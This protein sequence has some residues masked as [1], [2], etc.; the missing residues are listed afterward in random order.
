MFTRWNPKS[1]LPLTLEKLADRLPEVLR[2]VIRS[3]LSR[4]GQNAWLPFTDEI[5]GKA[6]VAMSEHRAPTPPVAT[7]RDAGTPSLF[8]VDTFV[9]AHRPLLEEVLEAFITD[10]GRK[11]AT[12]EAPLS[13]LLQRALVDLEFIR[14]RVAKVEAV[15]VEAMTITAKPSALTDKTRPLAGRLR[16][17]SMNLLRKVPRGLSRDA[18]SVS[19]LSSKFIT[20]EVRY[21]N[22]D[23]RP[24]AAATVPS[25]RAA[26][27]GGGSL[28]A[29]RPGAAP[30]RPT[31]APPGRASAPAE[32]PGAA[33]DRPASGAAA[34]APSPA[35][36]QASA[37]L[38]AN[39]RPD[40]EFVSGC[41]SRPSW[42]PALA[43]D[44]LSGMEQESRAKD[45]VWLADFKRV[46]LET[47]APISIPRG[48]PGFGVAEATALLAL[49]PRA[50][51]ERARKLRGQQLV[52]ETYRLLCISAR[53][54]KPHK[55]QPSGERRPSP[56]AIAAREE[57][58]AGELAF[59]SKFLGH[60]L[61]W[62]TL[63]ADGAPQAA[64][65]GGMPPR[66]PDAVPGPDGVPLDLAGCEQRV[67][68]CLAKA[69]ALQ[70]RF[71]EGSAR[72]T[73]VTLPNGAEL[74]PR[75]LG[76]HLHGFSGAHELRPDAALPWVKHCQCHAVAQA[77]LF[78]TGAISAGVEVRVASAVA[79]APAPPPSLVVGE[80]RARWRLDDA[81]CGA[82]APPSSGSAPPAYDRGEFELV[83]LL[84]TADPQQ[85]DVYQGVCTKCREGGGQWGRAVYGPEGSTPVSCKDHASCSDR[86]AAMSAKGKWLIFASILRDQ[87]FLVNLTFD[88]ARRDLATPAHARLSTLPTP[89]LAAFPMMDGAVIDPLCPSVPLAAC[90]IFLPWSKVANAARAA[91][92]HRDSYVSTIMSGEV[93]AKAL[94][95]RVAP[96]PRADAYAPEGCPFLAKMEPW[97]SQLTQSRVH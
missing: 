58:E 6:V 94:R 37:G 41:P 73:V 16:H 22:K 64:Q 35:G 56:E 66:G 87:A 85:L 32:G 3:T 78:S 30:R 14:Q 28:H 90:P 75:V 82:H 62:V 44:V 80:E 97:A 38:P 89:L 1:W 88:L 70:L 55:I 76:G 93:G 5:L 18:V 29:P 53:G 77:S 25:G 92:E 79:A 91:R 57:R 86:K 47:D 67:K 69:R 65:A 95:E 9:E 36:G 12:W 23:P 7:P 26:A 60:R 31:S 11:S 63:F 72:A 59:V 83:A 54:Y 68:G 71:V 49:L 19:L 8:A 51:L 50:D 17:M 43:P 20:L 96:R 39:R 48:A 52:V 27:S 34:G 33:R 13:A 81:S 45:E 15:A 42:L 4:W 10:V 74:G 2:S 61:G 46:S 24:S 84:A 21:A 40:I